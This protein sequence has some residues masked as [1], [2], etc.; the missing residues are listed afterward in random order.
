MY[1]RD[2]KTIA[3]FAMKNPDN[4][5]RVTTFVLTTIQA[6][7]ATTR[8]QMLDIDEHG[9]DSKYLW[10][11][12]RAGYEY[13]Q[14]HKAVIFAAIKAAVKAGDAVGA[15]DV[16]TNVPNLG[17][18]KAAFVA[19]MC[20][21]DVACIDSHNCDRLGL[22]RTAL[23]FPKGVKPETKRKKITDYVALTQRTG[24]SEYWW[25]TWCEYVAGNRANKS[26]STG[27]EV[28]MFHVVA[29]MG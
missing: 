22:A 12:K 8:N 5:A 6:G 23:K 3:K 14:E 27:N 26:L 25:N 18:V 15:I 20:G 13:M 16:L 4:L 21:L 1:N 24:G 19:Q 7:L 29:V 9:A 2:C 28:S 17:I 10:G 11:N